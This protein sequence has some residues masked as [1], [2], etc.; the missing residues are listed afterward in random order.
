MSF[1]YC[2]V[3][4]I[5]VTFISFIYQAQLIATSEKQRR[6]NVIVHLVII[7][8]MFERTLDFDI[9]SQKRVL[10]DDLILLLT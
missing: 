7:H 5:I 3:Y 10:I 1:E 8:L 2:L 6:K 9:C 4:N